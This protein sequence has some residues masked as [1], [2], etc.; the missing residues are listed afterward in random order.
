MVDVCC[1][2]GLTRA[3]GAVVSMRS[4]ARRDRVLPLRCA[5][6]AWRALLVRAAR[7]HVGC[8]VAEALC[9]SPAAPLASL[10]LHHP[11]HST[12]GDP[13]DKIIRTAGPG[14]RSH[15]VGN[16][17]S[18]RRTA[19][20]LQRCRE[21]KVWAQILVGLVLRWIAAFGGLGVRAAA[22]CGL[23]ALWANRCAVWE[24]SCSDVQ[25]QRHRRRRCSWKTK[26]GNREAHDVRCSSQSL[27]N[28]RNT[29]TT[30]AHANGRSI[31]NS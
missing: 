21:G 1:Q 18:T 31:T 9:C 20:R 12:F 3:G 23:K 17:S 16:V 2:A 10:R 5:R 7:R 29:L 22:T 27:A 6:Q 26:R 30:S 28:T 15:S 19:R 11:Q 13:A 8:A 24:G 4:E 25:S 14:R